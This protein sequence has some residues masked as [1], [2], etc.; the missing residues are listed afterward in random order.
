VLPIT[1]LSLDH[2]VSTERVSTGLPGLDQMFTGGGVYRGSSVLVSGTAG[3][4][5][6]SFAA[7]MVDAACRRS[8]RCVYFAFEESPAQIM[9]NMRSIGLDLEQ[10][11]RQGLLQF[12]ASRPTAYGLESHLATMHKA[13]SDF[14]P[15]IAVM[16]PITNFLSASNSG[17]TKALLMRMVDMLKSHGITGL[18]TS[19]THGGEALEATEAG[20]SSLID[21]WL[22]LRDN[23]VNG[24]RNRIM[25]L[26]KARGTAHSNQVREFLITDRGLRLVDAYT[27]PEGVLTGSARAALEARERGAAEARRQ[28]GE[29]RQRELDRKRCALESRIAA[30]RNEFEAEEDELERAIAEEQAQERRLTQDRVDMARL[31]RVTDV[32]DDADG[33]RKTKESSHRSRKATPKR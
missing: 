10:W 30:L 17:E 24:E 14:D 33:P 1:S 11:V 32:S 4:G 15:Q 5:K 19:L 13:I 7:H 8:E 6:S 27:G 28:A 26:I 23:E 22:L 25:F 3:T 9:R 20:M 29:R 18:F 2:H 31:R 12:Y 21:V 16:D